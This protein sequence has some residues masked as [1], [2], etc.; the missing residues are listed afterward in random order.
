MAQQL[1]T[2]WVLFFT[3]LLMVCF[4]LVIVYSASSVVAEHRYNAS[5]YYIQKQIGWAIVSFFLL[6]A[7]KRLDYRS[8][9]HARWAFAGMGLVL[10]LLVGVYFADAKT[11]RWI[12]FGPIGLQPSEFAKP[13]LAVFLAYFV[14]L[15]TRVI[16]D[17]HT[18][19]PAALALA[20]L[21][22]GVGVADLGTAIVL[23]L[24]GAAVFYVAGLEKRFLLACGGALAVLAVVAVLAKPYRLIRVV[25]YVDPQQTLVKKW[26]KDGRFREYMQATLA[27]QDTHYQ[28]Y[29]SVLAIG[30]GGVTGQGLMQSRQK[31][32]YLPEAHTDMI[33]A[34][35]GEEFGLLGCL[36][37]LAGFTV[38]VWRGLR[39]FFVISDDFGRYLAL[40]V[41][42]SLIT[43][44]LIN[45]GVALDLTPSKGIPLPMISYGGSSL[46]STL[47][48]TGLLLSVS[49]HA[50]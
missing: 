29:Q 11:H 27:T 31:M 3:T 40:A 49:E 41:T 1:K 47:L 5:T 36:A 16:N 50:G 48:S 4:G 14:S 6:M 38:V 8:L 35:V 7:L 28:Q 9:R 19:L 45:I 2:D 18:L 22:I 20:V 13:A 10:L 15:R 23:G 21:T 43:Q 34:V 24:T 44:A 46:L 32:L 12:R 25:G 42:I 26:D 17:R 33:F 30:S 39:L 37:L